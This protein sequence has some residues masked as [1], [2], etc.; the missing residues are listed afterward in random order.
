VTTRAAAYASLLLPLWAGACDEPKKQPLPEAPEI[1]E[2]LSIAD[3]PVKTEHRLAIGTEGESAWRITIATEKVTCEQLRKAYPG[4]PEGLSGTRIDFWVMQ[5]METDGSRGPWTFR[6]AYICDGDGERGLTARGA[7]L[8]GLTSNGE[9]VAVEE[10]ELACQDKRDMVMWN[11]PLE[12]RNCGRVPRKEEDRPQE[13]LTLTVAG[14][15][16]PIHGAT[17]R[18]QGKNFHLRLTHAPHACSSVFTEGYDFYLDLA[19]AGGDD[20]E[21]PI[22]LKFASLM[23][24][25]FPGDPAGSKGKEDF[26]LKAKEPVV[27]TGEVEMKV[28]GKLDVGGFPVTFDGKVKALRCTPM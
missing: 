20:E 5:P 22:E 13:D 8:G 18:P 6:S 19:F 12:A 10:L 1:I 4:R 21:T 17:V 23:G 16:I 28:K 24:D 7:Q 26:A 11:G 25:V 3:E 14:Q 9:R 2:G 27:G 15:T